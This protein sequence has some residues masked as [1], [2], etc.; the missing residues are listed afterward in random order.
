MAVSAWKMSRCCVFLLQRGATFYADFFA[1]G[2]QCL[3]LFGS[4][5]MLCSGEAV[6]CGGVGQ[7]IVVPSGYAGLLLAVSNVN[8]MG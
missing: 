1:F 2:K 7:N 6:M 8:M 4:K 5:C 3:A